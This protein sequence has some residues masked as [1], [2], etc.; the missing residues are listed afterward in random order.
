[1]SKFPQ[2][3]TR[4]RTDEGAPSSRGIREDHLVPPSFRYWNELPSSCQLMKT[5]KILSK[6][7]KKSKDVAIGLLEGWERVGLEGSSYLV[8]FM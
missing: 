4:E 1:M 3:Q 8:V 5:L 7:I 2:K 6:N